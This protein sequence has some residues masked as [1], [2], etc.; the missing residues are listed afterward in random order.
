MIRMLRLLFSRLRAEERGVVLVL[1]GAA[2][3]G[4]IGMTALTVDVARYFE[5]RRQLQ[6]GVDAAAHAAAVRLTDGQGA[7]A[8]AATEY[9]D[10]NEPSLGDATLVDVSF[11]N[12]DETLVRV[13]GE[14]TIGFLFAPL[15]GFL[16]ATIVSV[17]A[18][19]ATEA[20]ETDIM[21]ALDYTGSMSASDMTDLMN[22]ATIFVD[23]MDDS[24]G[25]GDGDFWPV[26]VGLVTF[27]EWDPDDDEAISRAGVVVPLTYSEADVLAGIDAGDLAG[28]GGPGG[29]GTAIGDALQD[30]AD[31][32][33]DPD[34][35]R[36]IV[37]MTDGQQNC[38]SPPPC[39]QPEVAATAA[40]PS[41]RSQE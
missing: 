6:N 32:F 19:V 16:D 11:P 23:I 30:S 5:L 35:R 9:W 8:A 41:P 27:P 21:L 18:M 3:F 31:A 12:G 15:L 29:F 34:V 2:M 28:S 1:V 7:A 37:F 20:P 14:A 33:D 40:L 38:S 36:I 25:G 4:L 26:R 17:V 39:A 24:S 13:E 22:A 10:L